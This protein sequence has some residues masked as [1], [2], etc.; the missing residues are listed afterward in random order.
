[1]AKRG[2]QTGKTVT[3]TEHNLRA[4]WSLR[5]KAGGRAGLLR[6]LKDYPE[7]KREERK[8]GP[9]KND[10][11]T[12]FS[13][14]PGPAEGLFIVRFKAADAGPLCLLQHNRQNASLVCIVSPKKPWVKELQ[15]SLAPGGKIKFEFVTPHQAFGK[16]VKTLREA[17]PPAER[18][19]LG[20]GTPDAITR[21]LTSQLREAIRMQKRV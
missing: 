13:V 21:R 20:A 18:W 3:P 12:D 17:L 4:L 5:R 10:F 1:M 7:P 14:D 16:I 2:K 15:H 11:F 8:R 19:R 9:R 6:W